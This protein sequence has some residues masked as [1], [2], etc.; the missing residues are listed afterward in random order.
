MLD[1]IEDEVDELFGLIA[2]VI[3][4]KDKRTFQIPLSDLRAMVENSGNFQLLNDY[5]VWCINY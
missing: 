2:N 5:S 1:S 4:E 3:R